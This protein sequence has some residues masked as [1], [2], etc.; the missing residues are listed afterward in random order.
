MSDVKFD[1]KDNLINIQGPKGSLEFTKPSDITVEQSG[2]FIKV[3]TKSESTAM[4]G[5]TRS[6]LSNMV[7][8]VSQG[9]EKKLILVGV[10]YRAKADKLKVELTVG[11]S[12]PV[13]F[14]IPKGISIETPSQTEIV[15]MGI[16]KQQV[17]QVAADMRSVRPPEPYKGKGIKYSDEEIIK[18]EAKKK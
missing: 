11:Y 14:E 17:G 7:T 16:D 2:N 1:L 6:L 13:H 9:W 4:S 5:T 3:S 10:G 12:H 18:K 8:G 15:I